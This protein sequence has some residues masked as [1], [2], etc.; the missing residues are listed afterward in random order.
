[1]L[2]KDEMIGYRSPMI[3]LCCPCCSTVRRRLAWD[4]PKAA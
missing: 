1:M 4:I 3:P 2:Q